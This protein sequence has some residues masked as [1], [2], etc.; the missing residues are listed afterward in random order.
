MPT[1]FLQ[2]TQDRWQA[3]SGRRLADFVRPWASL[4]KTSKNKPAHCCTPII[5]GKQ[6]FLRTPKCYLRRSWARD[7]EHSKNNP[8]VC[9]RKCQANRETSLVIGRGCISWSMVGLLGRSSLPSQGKKQANQH[10][11]A[12]YV[13]PKT[14]FLVGTAILPRRSQIF[15]WRA[16]NGTAR[17]NS[18][19]WN[20][21]LSDIY[22]CLR[23]HAS[24]DVL[25]NESKRIILPIA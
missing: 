7:P 11:N 25:R 19:K 8:L 15:L 20:F 4:P 5:N 24:T 3:D 17:N 23:K 22:V 9:A 2:G 1:S 13:F 21:V 10:P 14:A 12:R 18:Q 6:F 16:R